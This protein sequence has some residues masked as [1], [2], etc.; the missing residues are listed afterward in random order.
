[1]SAL[2]LALLAAAPAAAAPAA[3]A[4]SQV[5]A[6]NAKVDPVA[7]SAYV[8]SKRTV[9]SSN[10]SL[11]S[12][13]FAEFFG[14]VDPQSTHDPG[15]LDRWLLQSL[16]DGFGVHFP[17]SAVTPDAPPGGADDAAAAAP[18]TLAQWDARRVAGAH[19]ALLADGAAARDGGAWHAALD[20]ASAFFVLSR[21]VM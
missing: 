8:C 19:A 4:A 2:L 12:A 6:S 7:S 20:Q 10:G 13:F 9:A 3:A 15:C 1:M 17:T 5:V 16:P 14:P 18:R 11:D 21:N